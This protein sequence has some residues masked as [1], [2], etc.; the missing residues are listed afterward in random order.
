[1]YKRQGLHL[2]P[3]VS[4]GDYLLVNGKIVD[5]DRGMLRERRK[6]RDEGVIAV[7]VLLR[8]GE[9]DLSAVDVFVESRGWLDEPER[10]RCEEQVEEAVLDM[11][12]RFLSNFSE[13]ASASELDEGD[14][15]ELDYQI[16]R[17]AGK[18]VRAIT[19]RRPVVI[20][21]VRHMPSN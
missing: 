18:R 13:S 16:R 11:V 8:S 17:A 7:S 3:K 4:P 10:S 6:L 15:E 12:V 5:I 1:M 21:I 14:M 19:G 20:P 9:A 2:N